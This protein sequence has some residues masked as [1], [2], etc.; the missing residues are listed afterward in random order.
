MEIVKGRKYYQY[1]D[2]NR[3]PLI[4]DTIAQSWAGHTTIETHKPDQTRAVFYTEAEFRRFFVENERDTM[5][6]KWIESEY[7]RDMP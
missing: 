2:G 7:L 4:V 1:V 5:K 3:G 6:Q